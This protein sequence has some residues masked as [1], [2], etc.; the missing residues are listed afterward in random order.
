MSIQLA[1]YQRM[2]GIKIPDTENKEADNGNDFPAFMSSEYYM[3][4]LLLSYDE[5]LY[6]LETE[7][8][9]VKSEQSKSM[10]MV[11][12]LTSENEE[13]IIKFEACKK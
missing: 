2:V 8:K 5:Y 6:N 11:R 7:L 4:P 9:R 1:R 10:Q 13:L 3:A 12:S